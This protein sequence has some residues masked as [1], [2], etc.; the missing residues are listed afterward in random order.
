VSVDTVEL[1]AAGEAPVHVIE[2]SKAGWA[3]GMKGLLL[4]IKSAVG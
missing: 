2:T 1:I 4:E 3:T